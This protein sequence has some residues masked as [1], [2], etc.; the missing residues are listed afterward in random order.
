MIIILPGNGNDCLEMGGGMS[1]DGKDVKNW[2]EVLY[3]ITVLARMTMIM[4]IIMNIN[5]CD[6]KDDS[7]DDDD[8]SYSYNRVIMMMNIFSI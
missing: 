7:C 8:E 4:R 2:A 5:D 3:I 6:G 1:Y